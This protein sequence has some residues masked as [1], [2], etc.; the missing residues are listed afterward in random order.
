MF[1]SYGT[2]LCLEYVLLAL[3]PSYDWSMFY[4]LWNPAM[5]GVCFTSFGTQLCLEYVILALGPSYA[6]SM[7]YPA[8]PGICLTGNLTLS[9]VFAKNQPPSLNYLGC[10]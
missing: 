6:W 8:M 10:E 4:Y 3:E 2:Q 7:F 1:T 9:G 5:T